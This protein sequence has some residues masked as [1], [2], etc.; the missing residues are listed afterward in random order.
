MAIDLK[1]ETVL[2]LRDAA[3]FLPRRR[4]G[5]RPHFSTLYRWALKGF[6]G[7]RLE[8]IRIGGTLCTSKE[9][10]QRFADRLVPIGAGAEP[11]GSFVSSAS[12]RR[13]QLD[14]ERELD[15]AGI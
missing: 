3:D 7:V 11:M 14:A 4:R 1:T 13:A 10:L 8:T 6:R 12:R 5:K 2:S 15:K 9:A